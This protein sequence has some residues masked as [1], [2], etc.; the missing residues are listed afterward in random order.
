M[1]FD[2][3][4]KENSVTT[5]GCPN[6]GNPF[7]T[8]SSMSLTTERVEAELSDILEK[9]DETKSSEPQIVP[10]KRHNQPIDEV[11]E[12]CK[13]RT[14]DE[15]TKTRFIGFPKTDRINPFNDYKSDNHGNHILI[16]FN[17]LLKTISLKKLI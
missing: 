4:A 16:H 10:V 17:H 2:S 6:D 1:P 13:V 8:T 3:T 9:R 14:N 11:G 15:E 12:I 7:S 5:A